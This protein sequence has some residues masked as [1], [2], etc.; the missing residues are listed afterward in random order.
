MS[1]FK[2]FYMGYGEDCYRVFANVCNEFNLFVKQCE[3]NKAFFAPEP[4][5]IEHDFMGNSLSFVFN[6]ADLEIYDTGNIE[7]KNNVKIPELK[8]YLQERIILTNY[9]QYFVN[10]LIKN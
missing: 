3:C 6:W 4:G 7:K 9:I 8:K 10:F 1:A 5:I 2:D